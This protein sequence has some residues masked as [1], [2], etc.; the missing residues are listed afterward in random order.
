MDLQWCVQDF[1]SCG[2]L[3]LLLLSVPGFSLC[4]L[5]FSLF[6]IIS[7]SLLKFIYIA[8]VMQS[9]ISSSD[10]LFILLPS[11]FPRD[12]SSQS[13]VHIR[14]LKYWSFSFSISPS[15]EYSWLISLQINWFNLLASKW[16]SGVFSSTTVQRHQFFAA[17]PS[18]PFL[19]MNQS[20]VPYRVLTVVWGSRSL[21]GT[22]APSWELML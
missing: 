1:S 20:A 5:L 2:K 17:L 14:W 8:L 15:N 9:S 13:A 6:L 3:G 16:L 10:T 11:I 22:R 18:F 7:W 21:M 12:F 4:W 19:V